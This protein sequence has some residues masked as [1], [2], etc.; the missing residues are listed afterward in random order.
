MDGKDHKETKAAPAEPWWKK[1]KG[2]SIL[3]GIVILIAI[4]ACVWLIVH[5]RV[6]GT[7]N[8]YIDGKKEVKLV[9]D[10]QGGNTKHGYIQYTSSSANGRAVRRFTKAL[11]KNEST[12]NEFSDYI[13]DSGSMDLK[14]MMRSDLYKN[15]LEEGKMPILV[16]KHKGNWY[17]QEDTSKYT[18]AGFDSDDIDDV[19][20][21]ISKKDKYS[22]ENKVSYGFHKFIIGTKKKNNMFYRANYDPSDPEDWANK[23]VESDVADDFNKAADELEEM[24][25]MMD[26]LKN[27][28]ALG[29]MSEILDAMDDDDGSADD[30]A[31]DDDNDADTDKD[32]KADSSIDGDGAEDVSYSPLFQRHQLVFE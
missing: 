26:T 13:K 9:I 3:G 7:Y 18:D 14:K 12:I 1:N 25:S 21:S 27:Y 30:S 24:A 4:V 2:L 28:A 17:I 10:K 11:N 29:E 19:F 5:P 20:S 6:Y 15:Y 32:K 8:G 31:L 22:K 23:K 16:E